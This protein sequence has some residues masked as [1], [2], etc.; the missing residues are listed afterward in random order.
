MCVLNYQCWT[1]IHWPY[2][3]ICL[4][5]RS[6]IMQ[7]DMLHQPCYNCY[8]NQIQKQRHIIGSNWSQDQV[9][10]GCRGKTVFSSRRNADCSALVSRNWQELTTSEPSGLDK[11]AS[12]V[13][14]KWHQSG[15]KVASSGANKESDSITIATWHLQHQPQYLDNWSET[16][17]ITGR[18]SRLW[19]EPLD[20][21][22]ADKMQ[23]K[24]KHES[25]V[26]LWCRARANDPS[27]LHN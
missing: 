7:V 24:W 15:I 10:N 26:T 21:P 27:V 12:S 19:S 17:Q 13:A 8:I 9:T 22:D 23:K 5:R 3:W 6:D 25:D 20:F 2:N 11:V 14:S 18:G 16:D 4:I 1:T